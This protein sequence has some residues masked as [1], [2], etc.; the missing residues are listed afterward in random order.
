MEGKNEL[1]EKYNISEQDLYTLGVIEEKKST[2]G[3]LDKEKLKA[4]SMGVL[5][6]YNVKFMDLGHLLEAI[7]A[8][9]F[10]ADQTLVDKYG[11]LDLEA[12]KQDYSAI[13]K[14]ILVMVVAGGI[15]G[16]IMGLSENGSSSGDT[17]DFTT[18]DTRTCLL[19]RWVD[20]SQQGEFEFSSD[21][22]FTYL[23]TMFG[24]NSAAGG[25]SITAPGK[26]S[27]SY[28]MVFQGNL[29]SDKVLSMSAGCDV[30][31]VGS[32]RY[33]KQ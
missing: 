5:K 22:R 12:T 13:T 14:F 11:E 4:K 9:S 31:F 1:F 17:K 23:T 29:P 25:W 24:G 16:A 2:S 15:I 18:S 19:G 28:E 21:G 32:T 7:K 33:S 20:S 10:H 6:P 26:I 8:H 27:I 3:W 30:L